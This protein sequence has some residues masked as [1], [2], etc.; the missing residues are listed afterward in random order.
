M[1]TPPLLMGA[2]LLFWGWQSDLLPAAAIMAVILE[3]S[4]II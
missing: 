2:G 3:C 4:R 1:R